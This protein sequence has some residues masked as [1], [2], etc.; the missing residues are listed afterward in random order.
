MVSSDWPRTITKPKSYVREGRE[1][2]V[3]GRRGREE[4]EDE[5]TLKFR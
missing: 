3:R 4:I 2:E 1:R 5:K